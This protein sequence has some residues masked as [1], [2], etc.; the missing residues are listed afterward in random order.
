M[1]AT[2]EITKIDHA[3]IG[4]T[5]NFLRALSEPTRMTWIEGAL[6]QIERAAG[7]R[8]LLHT[9]IPVI[10]RGQEI[11][12]RAEVE[13]AAREADEADL[14]V[15]EHWC[16][17]LSHLALWCSPEEEPH[18]VRVWAAVR[19]EIEAA[20]AEYDACALRRYEAY[21]A[22]VL[23]GD[24]QPLSREERELLHDGPSKDEDE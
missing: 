4:Q 18:L 3:E 21:R 2:T 10:I 1:A 15:P 24:A 23:H 11:A 7:E 16:E 13:R 12:D 9:L 20:I 5:L 6:P 19:G 14:E 8:A 17:V 22:A